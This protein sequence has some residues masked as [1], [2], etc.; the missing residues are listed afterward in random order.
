MPPVD[1]PPAEVEAPAEDPPEVA[2][3]LLVP[4]ARPVDDA[5]LAPGPVVLV[6][7]PPPQQAAQDRMTPYET[8][9]ATRFTVRPIASFAILN[10]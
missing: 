6:S 3:A 5:A 9:N 1:D 4:L 8:M 10:R 7:P 2:A